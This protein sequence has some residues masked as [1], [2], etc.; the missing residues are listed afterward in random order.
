MPVKGLR[1]ET[2]AL[3]RSYK[4][5]PQRANAPPLRDFAQDVGLVRRYGLLLQKRA[6][7]PTPRP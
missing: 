5:R 1:A 7:L 6:R 4:K 2:W 3:V